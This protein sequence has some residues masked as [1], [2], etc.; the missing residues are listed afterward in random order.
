MDPESFKDCA[1]EMAEYI[2]NYLENIRDRRVLPTVEPGYM[3]PLLPSEA[4]Q[5]PEQWKDIMA[6]IERV[7]M[8][9]V[10]HWQSPKFH[11]YFPSIQSY[12]AILA[13]MLIGGISCIGFSWMASPACTE[14]EMITVD[15]LGKMLGLPKEFL[16]CSGGKGG[17]VIEGSA[18]ESTLLALLGAK[19]KKIKQ[20]KEQHPDWTENEIVGKLVAYCSCQAHASVER[21]GLMGGI[22]LR[23]LEVDDKYKLRGDT[24]AE[25]I[26]NDK[27]NGFIPFYAV[28]ALGTT[29][30]CA[31]D[32]LD[33]IGIVAN[34]ED[35][36]L[37]V[38]AA[39]AG[40]AFICPEFRYLMKGIEMVDSFNFS[41]HK[42]MLTSYDCSV[43][44]LQDPTYLIN[45]FNVDPL[46]LKHD[47]QGAAP[48]Y[49]HWQIPLGRRF[50]S[51]K[52]WFV[53][54][55]YGVENLQKFIRSHVAQAHEFEALVL[56]DPRFQI[57]GEVVMGLVCFRLKG[58]NKLNEALLKKINDAG[59]V[60]LVSS[61][62]K[63][64]NFLR[65]VVCSRFSESK[66]IQYSWK[67]IQLRANEILAVYNRF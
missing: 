43:M 13:D 11:A 41:P 3:R 64:T 53:L 37:H 48:D 36:W 49:R 65:F 38:D 47:M 34:R 40:A 5:T 26:R 63:C 25:A 28:A 29:N 44:W 67:E 15:W 42:W 17:G 22:K 32:R 21:A 2:A 19:A 9:G 33:E 31:F 55:L 10:T 60:H 57:I 30:T 45:A 1:K 12:P 24:F 8:P 6:D 20:V 66:D 39:Y 7:I 62:V 46:Y 61:K 50:R 56:S 18:S 51:L 4:P 14:L 58:S 27:E 59:N 52:L 16:F 54:R 23:Q 35:V